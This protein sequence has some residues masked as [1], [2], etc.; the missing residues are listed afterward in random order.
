M[1]RI[2]GRAYQHFTCKAGNW[3]CTLPWLPLSLAACRILVGKQS[4]RPQGIYNALPPSIF[5]GCGQHRSSLCLVCDCLMVAWSFVCL[6]ACVHSCV[7]TLCNHL[8]IEAVVDLYLTWSFKQ[9]A[10][11]GEGGG[12]NNFKVWA[13]EK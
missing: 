9:E 8:L 12:E 1:A 10:Q 13:G 4:L 6:S 7:C 3:L 5:I 11:R 2:G